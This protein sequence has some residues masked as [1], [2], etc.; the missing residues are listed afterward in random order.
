MS[1]DLEQL[2]DEIPKLLRALHSARFQAEAPPDGR[3]YSY[4]RSNNELGYR[5]VLGQDPARVP[6]DRLE[7]VSPISNTIIQ[8]LL[9]DGDCPLFKVKIKGSAFV[10][11]SS[12]RQYERYIEEG[13]A[14]SYMQPRSRP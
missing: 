4:S 14:P 3:K 11:E 1:D 8:Q 12:V 2:K 9:S 10:P 7:E 6:D 13:E 5:L